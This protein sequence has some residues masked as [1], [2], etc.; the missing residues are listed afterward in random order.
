[1]QLP[2]S[3]LAHTGPLL[4]LDRPTQ[5]LNSDVTLVVG[6]RGRFILKQATT[7]DQVRTVATET[8][9]LAAI[10]SHHPFVPAPLASAPGLL[11][12]T[13]LPGAD[14]LALLPTLTPADSHRLLAEAAVA[15]RRIHTWTPASLAETPPAMLKRIRDA[16]LQ[17]EI[18]F[19]HGDYCVPNIMVA[20]GRVSGVIDWPYAG[21]LDR[22]IDL[23]SACKSIRWNFKEEVFVETFLRAYGYDGRDLGLFAELYDEFC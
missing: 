5:G 16:G 6:A 1:M 15:L 3:F 7:A 2:D 23:A 8:Q 21:Y 10:C 9:I 17:P 14:L 4:A 13:L 19:C 22:R 11:L 18:T 20:G 12:M